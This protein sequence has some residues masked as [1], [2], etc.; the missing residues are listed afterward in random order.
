MLETSF[1]FVP[2]VM[3]TTPELSQTNGETDG[4]WIFINGN[5][6]PRIARIDLSTFETA[7]LFRFLTVEVITVHHLRQKI[8]SM[9]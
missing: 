9:L 3:L 4:R 1:G 8:R 6:T 5:N 7:E 2:W